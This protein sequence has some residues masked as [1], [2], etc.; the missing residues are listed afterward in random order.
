MRTDE[1]R[2]NKGAHRLTEFL[3][4]ALRGFGCF[5]VDLG[6]GSFG[7]DLHDTLKRQATAMKEF[8]YRKG[9]RVPSQID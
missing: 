7:E 5:K 3:V 8:M 4:F 1:D 6:I 2:E 9:I